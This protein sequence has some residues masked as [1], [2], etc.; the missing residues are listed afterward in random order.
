MEIKTLWQIIIK[1]I[2]LWFLVNCLYIIPQFVTTISYLDKNM[3]ADN[4]VMVGLINIGVLI[5][6]LTVVNLFLF[7]TE[8]LVD[9]LKLNQNF[10]QEKIDINISSNT[11]L[12]IVVIIIGG[13]IFVEALPSFFRAFY[14]FIKQK[15]LINE[16]SETSWLL[17]HFIKTLIGYLIMTNSKTIVRV[18]EKQ[19]TTNKRE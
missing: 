15:E 11:V 1:G 7:K 4:L 16:Y 3:A 9:K 5:I 10:T 17:F 2:G 13:L 6:Y 18:I 19:N 12:S 14:E 8:W